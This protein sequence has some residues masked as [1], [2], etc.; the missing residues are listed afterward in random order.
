[1]F[2]LCGVHLVNYDTVALSVE[3]S[4]YEERNPLKQISLSLLLSF[5]ASSSGTRRL[6]VAVLDLPV[7]DT[8]S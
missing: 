3:R 2:V 1:M 8:F 4:L 5:T 6:T 7:V